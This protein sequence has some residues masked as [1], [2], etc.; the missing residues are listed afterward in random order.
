MISSR[1]GALLLFR[2]VLGNPIG[3]NIKS[4]N[5]LYLTFDDGP[6][7]GT[8]KVLDVLESNG[9]KATFFIN[10]VNLKLYSHQAEQVL[11]RLIAAGHTLADHSYDHM[12][13]NRIVRG[14]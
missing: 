2:L 3:E 9:L 13:H 4:T 11:T 6:N 12:A 10:S 7:E 1:I 5:K 14:N 8:S